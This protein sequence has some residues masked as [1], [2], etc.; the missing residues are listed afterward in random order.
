MAR[1]GEA[2]AEDATTDAMDATMDASETM[3]THDGT[4][5]ATLDADAD[6]DDAR[7]DRGTETAVTDADGVET[8]RRATDEDYARLDA[9]LTTGFG[10]VHADG[11]D[12]EGR[13]VVTINATR[14]PGWAG[15]A[16]R[17]RAETHRARARGGCG[18]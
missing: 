16:D 9:Y 10:L 13:T 2:G 14:I 11:R 4:T 6:A 12:G 3:A 7:D 8:P 15:G 5:T 17:A 18:G 1:A